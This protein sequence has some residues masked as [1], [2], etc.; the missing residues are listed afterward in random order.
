[1]NIKNSKFLD[2]FEKARIGEGVGK[3]DDQNDPVVM[4]LRHKDVKECSHNYKTFISGAKPGRIV[5]PSEVHIRDTRQIPFEVDPPVHK[6][7]R[8]LLEDWFRRPFQKEYHEK[9]SKQ[10][11]RIVEDML[12]RDTVEV[13]TEFSLPL[14]SRALTLLINVPYEEADTWISWG[15]HVFRSDDNPLDKAKANVLYSYLDQQ[16][17]KA[18]ENPGD[19]LYS[20][21]L[22]SEFQGRKLT[23]EEI[24]GIMILTFAGGR[25]TIINMV[26]NTIAYLAEH[27][28]SIERLRNE[29]KLIHK[30]T[31]ELVRFFSPLT[32]MGRVVTEDT[33]VCEHAI[34]HDSRISLCW[35]SANR[36]ATV[37]ENPNTVILDRKKNPHVAFGW[38]HHQCLGAHH[39]RKILKFL[40]KTIT[41]KIQSIQILDCK[42]KIEHLG[43]FDRKV[44]F[45]KIN[46][47]FHKRED[48]VN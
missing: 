13:V 3:M 33:T 30:A 45:E 42:E 46:V 21:L 19:D 7:Y 43:E 12:E 47:K 15:T 17:D 39:S 4:V 2:P 38:S 6:E 37:F 26:T 41:E 31:E 24:N 28:E 29:P 23:K 48:S 8:D 20:V 44:G 10:I 34:N 25:D 18:I 32:H 1:M 16:I 27:P 14:Q 5:V 11:D 9:L 22:N 35:A 36:D 40:I